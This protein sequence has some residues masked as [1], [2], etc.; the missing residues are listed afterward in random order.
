MKSVKTRRDRAAAAAILVMGA[1]LFSAGAQ[2]AQTGELQGYVVDESGNPIKDARVILTSPQMIGGPKEATTDEEGQFRFSQLEPGLYT[3]VLSHATFRGFEER[4]VQVG[5]DAKVIRDYLLEAAVDT[6][7]M[8]E[9]IKVTAARPMVDTT[10]I[11]QGQYIRSELTDRLA[12]GRDYQSVV[13]LTAGTLDGQA[14]SGNP[15]IHGGSPYSNVYLLDGLNITD[16]VT[17]TFT[18]N[19]NFDAIGELQVLT[20]GLDA[21]YGSTHGGVINI[22]TRSGGD[23]FTLDGSVYWSPQQLQ[24]LDKGEVNNSNELTANIAVGGPIIRKKLW[25]FLSGQYV[26]SV[27]QTPI[28]DSPLLDR[29]PNLVFPARRFNAFY[30]LGKLKWAVTPWQKLSILVQSDPTW[31]TNETQSGLTHPKAEDQRVQGCAT[32][33]ATSE[34]TRSENLFWK[35]QLGYAS[36]QLFVFPMGCPGDFDKCAQSP[37]KAHTN[38]EDGT[39]S[40]ISSTLTDDRRFR[41]VAS[42]SLSYFLEGFLGDHEFKGGVEAAGTWQ[43]TRDFRPGGETYSDQ[44]YD[45]AGNPVPFQKTVY[46]APLEKTVSANLF[47]IYVQDVWRPFRALTIR[48]GLRFDS[49]RGYADAADDFGGPAFQFNTLSPRLGAA[50]DPL[51][52]GKT[53]LRGGYFYYNETG[54]LV[55]PGFVGR[56]IASTTYSFNDDTQEYS[57][58]FQVNDGSGVTTAKKDMKAPNMHEVT[59]GVQRELIENTALAV[60]FTWRRRQN[61][62]EDDESNLIWD[63]DGTNVIGFRNGKQTYLFS[64]GTPDE[65]FAEYAGVDFTFEKRLADNWQALV[66]Y[67]L[68]R[69]EGTVTYDQEG[70]VLSAGFDNPQQRPY[71]FG[72]GADDVRHKLNVSLSYDLPYG[73]QVGGSAFYKSGRPLAKFFLNNFYGAYQDKRA[74]YGYDPK[75]VDNPDDDVEYRAPDTFIA[76][77]R[78]AWRLKELTTQDIWLIADVFNVFNARPPTSFNLQDGPD[79]GKPQSKGGPLNAQVAVRYM[80]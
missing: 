72:F 57:R 20:A 14:A 62:F 17:Q 58:V 63:S 78:V 8:G 50:W 21:E 66:T 34:T 69:L 71:E 61:I 47:S 75:D 49:S 53:V 41:L 3:V 33:W 45:A 36:N 52:D 39:A 16:P 12:T 73:F 77:A 74:G 59:F 24:L 48:P 23:E 76:S 30:G 70:H 4:D 31:L 64:A 44:G 40:V 38:Q 55:I 13:L 27:A 25:F 56:G 15:S 46:D 37:L 9:V 35:T 19:F 68:S 11:T 29:D 67:T 2:A 18:T 32:I 65:A 7:G 22:V 51:G 10:R 79:F 1:L 42:S 28:T 6:A 5:I 26:D 43:A 80:F 60:D 54:W